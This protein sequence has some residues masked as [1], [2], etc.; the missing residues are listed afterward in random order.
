MS[1]KISLIITYHNEENNIQQALEKIIDQTKKPDEVILINSGSTDKS[2]EIVEDFILK[3][4]NNSKVNFN[5]FSLDT[6][7]PSTSKNMGIQIAKNDLV[8]FMDCGLYFDENWLEN[9]LNFLKK[10]NLHVVL[11]F[12][13]LEGSSYF[14]KAAVANTY[15]HKSYSDCIPGSLMYKEIFKKIGF[16]EKSRSLYDVLWKQKLYRSKINFSKNKEYTLK[17]SETNYASNISSLFRKSNLY[18]SEKVNVQKNPRTYIYLLAP[19]IFLILASINLKLIIPLIFI[20]LLARYY[21]SFSKSN[22]KK[23]FFNI[24]FLTLIAIT[25]ITIDISRLFGSINSVVRLVG[26]NYFII[27]FLILYFIT[28]NTPFISV[29]GNKLITNKDLDINIKYE[30]IIVFSGDGDT[31]Y[32]NQTYRQRTFD[33]INYAKKFNTKKILLSSGRDHQLSEVE[34]LRLF[35]ID[36]NIEK[37]KI[38][39]FEKFPSSTYQNIIMVGKKIKEMRYK[40]VI[41]IT[42]PFHYKRSMLIWNKNF[43]EINVFPAKNVKF[44]YDQFKW[45][46]NLDEIKIITYEYLAIIYNY[47]KGYM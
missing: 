35:L 31:S 5:N 43:K 41:F 3:N 44:D 10:N 24:K 15:G 11:G 23:L 14:D 45:I 34:L 7:F 21:K 12:I 18:T 33:A 29:M 20:Y 46:Q 8:A 38:F 17:Y 19:I 27:S 42:A 39:I 22:D 6:N 9:Q 25:A 13:K 30:A 4:K 40:N 28:F 32:N 2:R 1:D 26:S 36:Q 37:E 47:T 16:F